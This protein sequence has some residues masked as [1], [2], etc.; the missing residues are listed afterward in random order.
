MTGN[1]GPPPIALVTYSTKPRGGVAHTLALGEALHALGRQVMIVGLGDPEKGFFRP[2]AAPTHVVSA[3]TVGGGLEEKVAANIDALE[4]ALADI[5]PTHPILHTQDC[6]SARAAARVRDAGTTCRVVRTVHHVDDFDSESLMDCQARAILEPDRILVVT[7]TWQHILRED[8]GVHA[9]VVPNG[10][11]PLR[12][13]QAPPDLVARL[14][15]RVGASDR[16]MLLA[17]GGIEPRKGSD[18]LV[19]ALSRLVG[20]RTPP[21]VLAVLGGHSFQDHRAYRERVLASLGPLGLT[22]GRDVVELGTVPEEEMAAWYAA[23]DVLAFPSVKEGFGLAALEAMAAGVPVVTSDLP[24]FREWLVPGRDAL[25]V[26][27]G[28]ADALADALSRALDDHALRDRLRTAGLA[29]VD[30]YTWTASAKRHLELYAEVPV[31][32]P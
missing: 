19:A 16:P 2:V 26:P 31:P 29:L 7:T 24:V 13:R 27:V 25:L 10:V 14:R 17:V 5:A 20:R 12:Y 4:I 22:L 28:D 3:P 11:D 9:A 30:G 15:A 32:T 18:T 23:A 6:I 1:P 21:P 8:Y